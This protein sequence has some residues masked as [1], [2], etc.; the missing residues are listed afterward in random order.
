MLFIT[1]TTASEDL[2][3]CLHHK[4]PWP[5]S[6]EPPRPHTHTGAGACPLS[7]QSP[8]DR[9]HPPTGDRGQRKKPIQKHSS[10]GPRISRSLSEKKQ[11]SDE[12][13]FRCSGTDEGRGDELVPKEK[14]QTKLGTGRTTMGPSRPLEKPRG[15]G[16]RV[17]T[18]R[19][20]AHGLT[21]PTT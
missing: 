10:L 21:R 2:L 5:W 13:N 12:V 16:S 11:C 17:D 7:L 20:A 4:Q 9:Q 14:D 18:G 6:Q 8:G 15:K 19:L 1:V 3:V